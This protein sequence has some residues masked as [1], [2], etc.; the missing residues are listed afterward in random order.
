MTTNKKEILPLQQAL[1]RIFALPIS[2]STFREIQSALIRITEGNRE[3]AQTYLDLLTKGE[4]KDTPSQYA[5]IIEEFHIRT[6]L[7]LEVLEK[8]DFLNFLS[9]DIAQ[10]GQ[11]VYFINRI[12]KVDGGEF[13]FL[14]DPD[15]I[16][17]VTEHFAHRLVE[18]KEGN[19]EFGETLK[20][21]LIVLQNLMEKLAK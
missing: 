4:T 11:Q 19:K 15:S 13:Q 8:G 21:R 12:R 3:L 1:R 5:E 17:Q 7:A 10:A 18:L 6:R 9:S 14:T 16:L 2:R 20:P